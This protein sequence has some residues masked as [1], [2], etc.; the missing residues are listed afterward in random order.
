M[1]DGNEELIQDLF[2][3]VFENLNN[4]TTGNTVAKSL[5]NLFGRKSE[6]LQDQGL[7]IMAGI[8]QNI[9]NMKSAS[10]GKNLL[11]QV[12]DIDASSKLIP[13]YTTRLNEISRNY[14][15]QLSKDVNDAFDLPELADLKFTGRGFRGQIKAFENAGKQTQGLNVGRKE[16]RKNI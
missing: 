5:T 11:D 13:R 15:N 10:Q 12:V 1:L 2:G 7:V 9:D 4:D 3:K 14:K 8:K 16:N 6:N